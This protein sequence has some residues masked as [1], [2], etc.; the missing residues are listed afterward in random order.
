MAATTSQATALAIDGGPKAFPKMHGKKRPKIGIEEFMSIA[1]R[2]GFS[3]EALA[4]I[5]EAI[6]EEDLGPGPT[7]SRFLTARPPVTKGE[8]FEKLAR[9]TFGVKYALGVSS[10]TGALHA[11]MVAA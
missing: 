8:A 4:R 6:S 11:A 1:E 2:F 9:E 7:L 5:R 10:G 3:P